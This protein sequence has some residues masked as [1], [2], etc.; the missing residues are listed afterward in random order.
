MKP[1]SL[2]LA[3]ALGLGLTLALLFLLA[4][5][6]PPPAHADAPVHPPPL[7][8]ALNLTSLDPTSPTQPVRL[9]FIHHSCG[10][11]WLADDNGNLGIELMNNNYFVSDTNYGWGPA[12]T[13][14]GDRIG[15]HTD[16]PHWYLWFTGSRR[17]TYL[18]ALYAESGKHS[19]YSRLSSNPGGQNTIIM[20]KSC[21]PNS[22]ID[23]NPND[24]PAISADYN[25]PLDV[26]HA[27][28]IYLDLLNYFA[29]RQ[30]KLFVAIT[31]PPQVISNTNSI[32]ADNARA[33]NNWLVND[34]LKGYPYNN[35]AV[36][37]FYNVLTSNGGDPDTNDLEWADGNHHRWWNGTVQHIQTVNNNYSAYGSD[38]Y[39]SHPTAA[40]N[41][42]ATGEFV[43]LLN[44]YYHRWREGA[45]RKTP[46][47]RAPQHGQTVTYTIAVRGLLAPLTATIYLTDV[48]PT[49]LSYI[50]GTLTAT[51]GIVTDTDAPT[52]RWSGLLTPTP[53]VTVTYAVTVT[54][55]ATDPQ[56]ISNSAVIVAPGYETLT[57]T[58]TVR[59]NWR[60]F[61]LPVVMKKQPLK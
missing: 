40:G 1:K 38:P 5:R 25:S 58:A 6:E 15:D 3:L 26:A 54:V 59:A 56:V 41:Q 42:K 28:R 46:S 8:S 31:A 23:G 22:D 13:E 53:A 18:A 49:G 36:F 48:V 57:R 34:W 30:D 20:F 43:P 51:A 27:K 50:S 14:L 35:V 39:D 24:P 33:F 29:T 60:E 16:I 45:S 4:G 10:E 61:F 19:S 9:I 55:P 47:A 2:S 21:F 44:I 12:C 37:D 32:Y 52:L 11:H 17:D 7:E